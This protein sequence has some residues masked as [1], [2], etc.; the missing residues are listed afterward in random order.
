MVSV[1]ILQLIKAHA[2]QLLPG[3][4]PAFVAAILETPDDAAPKGVF[5]DWLDERGD[6]QLACAFRWMAWKKR[7]PSNWKDAYTEAQIWE[8]TSG[9]DHK[10]NA[11]PNY[12]VG[13]NATISASWFRGKTFLESVAHL[14]D[15]LEF[16]K[17]ELSPP[18]SD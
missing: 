17:E 13:S 3:D 16:L 15:R 10:P 18:V 8:W 14:S 7:H 4:V 11:L 9:P 1:T 5:A 6:D 12:I 2:E